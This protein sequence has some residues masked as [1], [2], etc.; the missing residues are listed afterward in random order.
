M[1]A[2]G[3][4]VEATP[5]LAV[6]QP[7]LH[8]DRVAVKPPPFWKADPAL[9][10]VQLEA[11]FALSRITS[12]ETKFH[13]VVSAIDTEIL[14][15]VADLLTAPP[16]ENKYTAIKNK[17]ITVFSETS[18]RKLRKLLSE[19]SLGDQKPSQLLMHMTQLGGTSV[20]TDMLRTLWLQHLPATIQ[21][22]LLANNGPV[23]ELA[24]LADRMLEIEQPRSFAVQQADSQLS[25]V[26][27]QLAQQVAAL[28]SKVDSALTSGLASSAAQRNES[29]VADKFPAQHQQSWDPTM[30]PDGLCWYHQRFGPKA[31]KCV[32][33][34]NYK[35]ENGP[36]RR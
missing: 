23:D 18:E 31:R 13:H 14:S 30:L 11:Q 28:S 32:A 29:R 15:H 6:Q 27:S 16:G 21:T 17:L 26:V 1:E 36:A 34:C 33:P 24:K 22:V 19:V 7:A 12:E 5:A 10:F 8:I 3:E 35:P 25:E 4:N 20:T 9:W 2:N